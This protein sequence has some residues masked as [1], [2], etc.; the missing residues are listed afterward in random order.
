LAESEATD[1]TVAIKKI[2][3]C[4]AS[5]GHVGSGDLFVDAWLEE[6][7]RLVLL[8]EGWVVEHYASRDVD[9]D[10]LELV[11]DE[12]FAVF[13]DGGTKVLLVSAGRRT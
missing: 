6:V 7:G 13:C 2:I 11:N 8:R 1:E 3:V 9:G 4:Y 12:D 10:F 5:C